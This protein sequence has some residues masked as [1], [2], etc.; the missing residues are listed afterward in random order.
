MSIIINL[1]EV[2]SA[3]SQSEIASKINFNF[4]QLIAL[5]VGQPGTKGDAGDIGPAGP[6]GPIGTKGDTGSV[7]FGSTVVTGN[8]PSGSV[9]SGLTTGD[10]LI[11]DDKLWKK[12]T[13]GS[14]WEELTDFNDLVVSA[15]GVNISP[16]LLLASSSRII[17]PRITSGI[18]LTNSVTSTDPNYSTP[19]LGTNY[20][21]VLYNFNET[22]TSSLKLSSGGA[23]MV[24]SNSV[25]TKSFS[26]L[27]GTVNLTNNTIT[28]SAHPY[29]TG[30]YVTYSS[31]G[32]TV[33]GGLVNYTGYYIYVDSSSTVKLCETYDD[34]IAGTPVIDLTSYGT[35]AVHKLISNLS[36][37]DKAFPATSNLA[38]YSFFNGTAEA[39]KEFATTAKGYRNQLELGS[40]DDLPTA[41]T[42]ISSTNY[43]ISPSF[44]NLR[45]R[46]YRLAGDGAWNSANPGTYYLRADYDLS[47]VGSETPEQFSP[48]RNSEQVW[49]INKAEADKNDGRTIEMRLT[50]ANILA[51]SD[52][53][54]SVLVDGI[55]LHKRNST[56]D[57]NNYYLGFGFSSTSS[58]RAKID[59]S[60]NLTHIQ[61]DNLAIELTNS[62]ELSTIS[63]SSGGELAIEATSQAH[64]ADNNYSITSTTGDVQI[65]ASD[66]N[67]FIALNNAIKVK[68]NRL[69]QGLPFPSTQVASSDVNTLDHYVEGFLGASA[70]SNDGKLFINRYN[71]V[72]PG[73]G[74]PYN[75]HTL[76]DCSTISN[77]VS[78]AEYSYTRIGRR[79]SVNFFIVLDLDN[80][81]ADY[82]SGPT[83]YYYSDLAIKLPF[84]AS[85]AHSYLNLSVYDIST[86]PEAQPSYGPISYAAPTYTNMI[87]FAQS[88]N[89]SADAFI[90][91]NAP[92]TLP[93]LTSGPSSTPVNQ[94]N[95]F[96]VFDR[97]ARLPYNSDGSS[98][99]TV[100]IT[101]SGTYDTT[102]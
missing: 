90:Y 64:Q 95:R 66:S 46:K 41:Y 2:F 69:A 101:G 92:H 78:S 19:G 85:Q 11:S 43:L 28:I 68:G 63:L 17:K 83:S 77:F 12:V 3:D 40:I 98:Y 71:L 58:T 44:E 36:E 56:N 8:T 48:R 18:D 81:P 102:T 30:D 4:N 10:I 52:S 100:V 49:K 88:S 62:S 72:T 59:A 32:G 94:L 47:S 35:G 65:T 61:F 79:V 42:G 1:K 74:I 99:G 38:L 53:A 15:I 87:G 75:S 86:F 82:T 97:S 84:N 80:W 14:G 67:N 93:A 29:S 24:G 70:S 23:I 13:T 7:I 76:I 39:A 54:S 21:T 22:K 37:P 25:T 73:S 45:I 6:I 50:N 89:G 57:A 91:L 9:P 34:A 26:P 55:L 60:A 31:E 16:Y 96:I 27:S 33:I 51:H 20:Q 5:G